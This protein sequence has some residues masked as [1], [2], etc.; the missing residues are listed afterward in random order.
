MAKFHNAWWY[1]NKKNKPLIDAVFRINFQLAPLLSYIGI[2]FSH[3]FSFF[4]IHTC[5]DLCWL[6]LIRVGLVLIRLVS[7]RTCVDLRW[8]V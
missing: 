7:C 4:V 3:I 2:F 5:V 8:F 6:V 1:G